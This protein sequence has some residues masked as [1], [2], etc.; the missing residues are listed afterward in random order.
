MP[1]LIPSEI[2]SHLYPEVT[3]AI[4]RSETD[5]TQLQAAIDAAIAETRGYLNAYDRDAI[6]S[7]VG[8]DRNPILLLYCKDIAV[9]HF[10][11]LSNPGVEMDLRL[12]R[13][14]KAV[15]WLQ[16]V[17]SGRTNP[18]LPYPT[19]PV[20]PKSGSVQNSFKWGGN[21]R[22]PRGNF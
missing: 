6:F 17:Q 21:P 5:T 9:W 13:Y 7:A 22:R 16:L 18:D 10:I 15:K 8:S 2:E 19:A 11:Q 1:F 20:D 12:N 4:N 14:E 3:R